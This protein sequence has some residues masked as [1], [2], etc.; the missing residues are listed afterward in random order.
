M[1]SAHDL[2]G[3]RRGNSFYRNFRFKGSDGEAVD[4]TGSVAVFV[5]ESGA[6]QL[7]K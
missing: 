7:V 5:V 2:T 4:L 6:V 3:L 1:T